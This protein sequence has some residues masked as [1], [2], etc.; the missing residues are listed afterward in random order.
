MEFQAAIRYKIGH[1][2]SKILPWFSFLAISIS[3]GAGIFM[4]YDIDISTN[5]T[6]AY[7]ALMIFYYLRKSRAAIN[8]S[9]L[10]DL[11][12]H[13]MPLVLISGFATS[14]SSLLTLITVCCLSTRPHSRISLIS[15]FHRMA[16][17]FEF[18]RDR[19]HST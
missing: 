12:L 19:F 8:S 14:A 18:Y 9:T 4:V 1:H 16:T 5:V 7:N 11:L 6:Y 3:L 13:L 17:V 10:A 2:F 15:T